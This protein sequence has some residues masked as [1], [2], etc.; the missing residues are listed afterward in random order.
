MDDI[1]PHDGTFKTSHSEMMHPFNRAT[2][3]V[4]KSKHPDIIAV[5][6][7]SSMIALG[8]DTKVVQLDDLYPL[9]M[10]GV[11]ISDL[12]YSKSDFSP[13]ITLLCFNTPMGEFHITVQ[14]TQPKARSMTLVNNAGS[15]CIK[16]SG[17]IKSFAILTTIDPYI[18]ALCNAQPVKMRKCSR[19]YRELGLNV[20]YC[21]RKCQ[22]AHYAEHRR[23]CGVR[24]I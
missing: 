11:T 9:H 16:I 10:T 1:S 22:L 14:T 15:A 24:D 5:K 18:C 20:R 17:P 13:S 7:Q 21:N 4:F 3:A 6:L 12:I 2:L 8:N 23:V 19:C